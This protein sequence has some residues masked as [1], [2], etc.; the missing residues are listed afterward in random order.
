MLQLFTGFDEREALGWHVFAATALKRCSVPLSLHP[1]V[2]DHYRVRQGSN[3]FTFSR[4]LIPHILGF[5]GWAVFVDGADMLCRGDLAELELLRDPYAAVQVV[6]HEYLTRHPRKY[7]GTAM[8]CDNADYPRKNWASVMLINCYH[9][10]WRRITPDTIGDFTGLDL[11]GLRFID[12]ERIG[13]L[14]PAW[15]WLV[16]E[17]GDDDKAKLLHWTAGTPQFPA[18]RG[19]PASGEWLAAAS[20]LAG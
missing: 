20:G 12:D 18:Y 6:K 13:D 17:Y 11:L 2:L 3:A 10:A 1:I 19:A 5:R 14:P 7:L 15:N 8:E 16:D 9:M 4:F